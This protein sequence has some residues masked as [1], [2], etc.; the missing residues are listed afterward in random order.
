MIY[1]KAHSNEG[2]FYIITS[3]IKKDFYLILHI[4]YNEDNPKESFSREKAYAFLYS[5]KELDDYFETFTT[6]HLIPLLTN[7]NDDN[8]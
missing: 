8:S 1:A 6:E 7:L 4:T 2:L 3:D 5:K